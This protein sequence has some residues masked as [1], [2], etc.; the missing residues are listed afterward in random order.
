MFP[1]LDASQASDSGLQS[2]K[3]HEEG[4]KKISTSAEAFTETDLMVNN[5]AHASPSHKFLIN[6]SKFSVTAE[7][8]EVDRVKEELKLLSSPKSSPRWSNL[9]DMYDAYLSVDS[10]LG[11]LAGSNTNEIEGE[12]LVDQLKR[13]IEHVKKCMSSLYKDLEE[14]RNAAAIAANE[15]MSMINRLQEEKSVL[16][17]EALQYLR[18]MEEQA[19]H[20]AEALEKADILLSEKEKEIQDLEAEIEIYRMNLTDEPMGENIYGQTEETY[21]SVQKTFNT[22]NGCLTYQD[23]SV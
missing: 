11:F 2:I 10:G 18:M 4:L 23:G 20:D 3:N 14:E 13:Q 15:A 9:S 6:A 17:M 7:E 19:E 5:P 1:A 22:S 16:Q 21:M 8:R 12:P